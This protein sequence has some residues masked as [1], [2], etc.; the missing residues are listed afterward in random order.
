MNT[1]LQI[2]LQ[3][4]AA[5]PLVAAY[6]RYMDE[7]LV[8]QQ[9]SLVAGELSLALDFWQLH[10]AMLRC[11]AEIEDRYL[12]QVSAE[13]QASWRWPAT[14]YLAE[15]RK[16]LQFAERVEARLSAMQA[17]LALRQIVEEIDKQRSYKNLLEHHEERE[18]IALLL[19]MPKTAAVLT[20]ALER[21][22]VSQ[23]TQLYQAQQPSLASLQQRLQRLRR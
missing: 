10:V 5:A 22:I 21:D 12:E 6:H 9:E 19:E 16:I 13:Q 15:H 4:T 18:E 3:Q 8:L 17:P 23:W 1:S 11:H 7:L 14:L 20:A 2:D